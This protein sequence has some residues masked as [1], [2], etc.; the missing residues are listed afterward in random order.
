MFHGN[1]DLHERKNK[2]LCADFIDGVMVS[3]LVWSGVG[4]WSQSV[5]S[6]TVSLV[7]TAFSL[8]TNHSRNKGKYWLARNQDNVSEWSFCFIAVTD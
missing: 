6:K 7:F 2:R 1:L 3:V 5:K 8:R 4:S